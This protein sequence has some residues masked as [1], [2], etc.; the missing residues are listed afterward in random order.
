MNDRSAAAR[1]AW[2]KRK[3]PGYI[4]TEVLA[5]L[6]LNVDLTRRTSRRT[7][8]FQIKTGGTLARHLAPGEGQHPVVRTKAKKPTGEWT[9]PEFA[10]LL[11]RQ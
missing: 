11:N 10:R 5:D 9:W 1:K 8:K 4:E 2:R 3:E 6:P 7:L